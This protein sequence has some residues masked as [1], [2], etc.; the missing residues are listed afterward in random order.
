[1]ISTLPVKPTSYTI[2]T[3]KLVSQSQIHS[4]LL[5]SSWEIAEKNAQ[6]L[7]ATFY[8][9]PKSVSSHNV[10]SLLQPKLDKLF[11]LVRSSGFRERKI[12]VLEEIQGLTRI[13]ISQV[14]L[15]NGLRAIPLSEA[16]IEWI[17]FNQSIY[18]SNSLT[19]DRSLIRS[20]EKDLEP[21]VPK[22]FVGQKQSFVSSAFSRSFLL[23]EGD[24]TRAFS[25]V[26]CEGFKGVPQSI[27]ENFQA[28]EPHALKFD[29]IGYRKH[30]LKLLQPF[31]GRL[32]KGKQISL[33][34]Y[35][36]MG[37]YDQPQDLKLILA[38]LRPGF[39]IQLYNFNAGLQAQQDNSSSPLVTFNL[40]HL[41]RKGRFEYLIK[42]TQSPIDK[43]DNQDL[44]QFF[45]IVN[46]SLSTVKSV[47]RAANQQKTF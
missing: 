31:E 10:M 36:S 1:M 46:R 32:Q 29:E 34:A 22:S 6:I 12:S 7:K 30:M 19:S 3:S 35:S 26:A 16:Q 13:V 5:D 37:P 28:Y 45:N 14:G 17:K 42:R 43:L 25:Y 40:S 9:R 44:A 11:Y 38:E 4:P 20:L 41:N 39:H 8:R 47:I 27:S 23:Q 15:I 33:L 18:G 24:R 21:G 2:S